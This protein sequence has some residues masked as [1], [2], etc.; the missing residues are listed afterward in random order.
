MRPDHC[1]FTDEAFPHVSACGEPCSDPCPKHIS[2]KPS[3]RILWT[4]PKSGGDQDTGHREGCDQ[5]A[6][7]P[8]S[9]H[10]IYPEES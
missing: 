2:E 3:L 10:P 4:C 1:K 6:P 8:S 7:I 5:T 9:V